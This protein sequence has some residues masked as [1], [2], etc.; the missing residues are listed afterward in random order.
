MSALN[1]AQ[2]LIRIKSISP[3]DAGCFEVIEPELVSLGFKVEKIKELN[4]ETLLA[5]F[6]N[7]G[8]IFCYLGHT[9][10]VPSGPIEE[11]SS[12]PFEA[13]VVNDELIG[14]GA[15]DMKASV[16]AFIEAL[17]NFLA[18]C[19]EPN[20][21]IWMMLASNEEGEPQD[22]KINTLIESLAANNEIIDYC[23]VGEASSTSTV[24]DVLRVGRRGSLSGN[25]KLIGKQGHVAYPTKVL[26]P[27][28]EVGPIISDLQTIS[29]DQ[30]NE[31]FDPTSFQISNIDSG[32]GATNVVPGHLNMLFNFRF[33][34]ESSHESLKERFIQILEKSK[35]EFEIKWTLN[36]VPYLTKKT[37]LLNIIQSALKKIN[38][39][40]AV[41]D[42][43]G[44]TSDGRWV[45]PSGAEVIELGPINKTIH[46]IDE[47][48]SLSDLKLLT[49]I[50]NQILVETNSDSS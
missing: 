42:N 41:I 27:I 14:R 47:K 35:C 40:E 3:N 17:K 7:K 13:H 4:S 39:K 2:S 31:Y 20:F 16:A 44:G 38:N 37:N 24:G 45:S 26:S 12:H 25:L 48:I 18:T 6:G 36:A 43:G 22:G 32:T 33:S 49:R 46:Q 15:A 9:D 8:K 50:Y 30:G 21:Q 10:V 11:W 34:P 23:L 29:W 1:L 5:K 28:L 19:P